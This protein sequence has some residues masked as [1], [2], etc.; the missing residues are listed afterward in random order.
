MNNPVTNLGLT[1]IGWVALCI[2]AYS[3][4]CA[5]ESH[6]Q[7][8]EMISRGLFAAPNIM[9]FGFKAWVMLSVIFTPIGLGALLWA[10]VLWFKRKESN[11]LY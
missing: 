8:Q 11:E 9:K 5:Y 1:L 10:A 2:G 7:I 3:A 4:W 6:L